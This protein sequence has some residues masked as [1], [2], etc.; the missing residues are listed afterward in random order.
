MRAQF[1]DYHRILG[2]SEN[3]DD[4]EIKK[5][6]RNLA[7][8]FHPDVASDKEEA[9]ERFKQINEAYEVLTGREKRWRPYESGMGAHR[10]DDFRGSGDWQ[11]NWRDTTGSRESNGG[12]SRCGETDSGR[13]FDT[14]FRFRNGRNTASR[15]TEIEMLVTLDEMIRGSVRPIVLIQGTGCEHCRRSGC[16]GWQTCPSCNGTGTTVRTKTY[17]VK[18]P[19]GARNGQLFRFDTANDNGVKDSSA[20]DIFLR[21]RLA[22]HPVFRVENDALHCDLRVNSWTVLFGGTISVPTP[23]GAVQINIP[24]GLR[25]GQRLRLRGRGL[26]GT[27]G[28]R[29]DLYAVIRVPT[30]E[31]R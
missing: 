25:D 5:A 7:R 8:Q 30:V 12:R 16:L 15:G 6:F 20:G 28:L 4:V 19:A 9:E 3:A 26:P 17:Q 21:I 27:G 23:E 29:D 11:S 22:P 18:I 24:A 13:S 2:V 14:S 1:K 10:S 31:Q